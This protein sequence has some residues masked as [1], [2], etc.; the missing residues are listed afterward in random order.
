MNR[1]IS[2]R[3]SGVTWLGALWI[4]GRRPYLSL[5]VAALC[6][7]LSLSAWSQEAPRLL[8]NGGEP[9]VGHRLQVIVG[10]YEAL[11]T[12]W[13]ITTVSI[14]DPRIADAKSLETN[15]VLI[16]GNSVGVTDLI[17]WGDNGEIWSASIDVSL[18][19]DSLNADLAMLFP[20]TGVAVQSSQGVH[21]VK[22]TLE[23]SDQA[24]QLR[25]FLDASKIEYVD[26]TKVAGLQQVQIKVRIAEVNRKAI[27]RMGI[28]VLKSGSDFFGSAMIGSAS[29]GALNSIGIGDT[30]SDMS[31]PFPFPFSGSTSPFNTLTLGFPKEDLNFFIQALAENQYL[32]MLAEPTMVALSGQE[33]SFLAGGEFPIPVVQGGGAGGGTSISIEYKEFGVRLRFTPTVLGDGAIRLH[34]APEVSELSNLGAVVIEGFQIPSVLTRRA[35][36]TLELYSGQT[37]SMAGLLSQSSNARNSRVPLLGDLPVLGSLFRSVD[38]QLGESELVVLVTATL[39]EPLS[40][41]SNRA[42]PGDLHVIPNDWELFGIGRLE[43]YMRDLSEVS[44]DSVDMGQLE[45]LKGPGAWASYYEEDDAKVSGD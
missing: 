16:V 38:Y 15:E 14:A 26:M 19:I 12:S 13:K 34:V 40:H 6:A 11:R 29:G 2:D 24:H 42:V 43:G 31:S 37:F 39:V 18:D 4:E 30:G 33:A 1:A 8:T 35:E 32:H 5:L 3:S 44:D 23:R 36:T 7:L 45:E 17:L 9:V 10:G 22:G 20:G 28:N 41:A 21:F 25:Q 27:K